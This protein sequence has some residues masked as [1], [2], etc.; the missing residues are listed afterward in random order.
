LDGDEFLT[1]D[2]ALR[3][4][5]HNTGQLAQKVFTRVNDFERTAGVI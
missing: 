1:D 4:R 3:L 5:F 2:F